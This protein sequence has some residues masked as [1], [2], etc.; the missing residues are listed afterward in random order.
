MKALIIQNKRV[1]TKNHKVT[2]SYSGLKKYL[3]KKKKSPL[4]YLRNIF[5]TY[6]QFKK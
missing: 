5:K 2:L 6:L 4:Y 3:L 1:V